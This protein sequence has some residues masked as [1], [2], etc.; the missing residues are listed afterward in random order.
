MPEAR[1]LSFS[2]SC[3]IIYYSIY[4]IPCAKKVEKYF[5]KCLAV[6][7]IF[8]YYI[9]TF[10]APA[11]DVSVY[12]PCITTGGVPPLTPPCVSCS[13]RYPAR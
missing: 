11:A 3:N 8:I 2:Y 4:A 12:P 10:I 7:K 9:Y 6:R 1:S 5:T 13:P